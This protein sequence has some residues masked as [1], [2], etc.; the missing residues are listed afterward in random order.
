MTDE[1]QQTDRES[2]IKRVLLA[3]AVF[4]CLLLVILV[5]KNPGMNPYAYAPYAFYIMEPETVAEEPAE[6]GLTTTAYT[7]TVPDGA[8]VRHG[9]RLSVYLQ[10]SYAKVWLDGELQYS[11]GEREEKHIGKTPGNYWLTA[12]MRSDY[13]GKTLRLEITPVYK[14]AAEAKWLTPIKQA[15][16]P[17]KPQFLLID[18][19]QLL[20]QLVFPKDAFVLITAFFVL[21]AGIFLA[22]F[23][24][25]TKLDLTARDRLFYLGLLSAAAALWNLSQLPSVLLALDIY[26]L[27]KTVWNLGACAF[28]LMPVIMILFLGSLQK[29]DTHRKTQAASAIC[30]GAAVLVLALQ[31]FNVLDIFE[32]MLWYGPA[33]AVL[34]F[35]CVIC[36]PVPHGKELF[37]ELSFPLVFCVDLMIRAATGSARFAVAALVWVALNL[38]IRGA[39]F[40]NEAFSR[41]KKLRQQEKDLYEIRIR[42]LIQQIRPHF[43]YNTLSSVYV[44]CKNNSP[45]APQVIENFLAYLQA[46]FTAMAEENPIPFKDELE[47]TKAYIAVESVRFEGLLKVDY[48]TLHMDFRVPPLTLQPIVENAVKHGTHREHFQIRIT[49]RTRQTDQ[50]SEIIVEDNGP[51][52]DMNSTPLQEASENEIRIGLNNVKYRLK[53]MCGGT[54]NAAIRP[55]G[56]T[57]VTIRIPRTE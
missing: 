29:P 6:N 26:G 36:P 52:F 30:F 10:H 42:S 24:L 20:K 53:F 21:V 33:A 34:L 27:Q 7:F 31:L 48:D 46:N 35:V 8:K 17:G 50:G 38:I 22:L 15:A 11:S 9:A 57:V 14:A 4:I 25:F 28:I 39:G 1:K 43:I 18:H 45:R 41:E 56:G 37:L 2:F 47:H 16:A 49:V 13:S 54:L 40:V 23:S 32:S 12:A 55:E 5:Q 51:G 19:E 44:L 3:A